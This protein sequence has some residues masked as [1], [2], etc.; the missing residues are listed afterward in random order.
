VCSAPGATRAKAYRSVADEGN[1]GRYVTGN[2][3]AALLVGLTIMFSLERWGGL[4]WFSAL[5]LGAFG[6]WCLRYTGYVVRERHNIKRTMQEA[7]EA[8]RRAKLP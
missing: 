2:Q 5:A 6:Y 7:K 1:G 4:H 3:I 8:R